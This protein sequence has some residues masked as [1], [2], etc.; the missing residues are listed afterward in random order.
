[1]KRSMVFVENEYTQISD[2][3]ICCDSYWKSSGIA[4][5]SKKY[6]C[7]THQNDEFICSVY[8]CKGNKNNMIVTNDTCDNKTFII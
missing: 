6:V 3:K 5:I 7:C 4:K 1:M 8:D 2:K